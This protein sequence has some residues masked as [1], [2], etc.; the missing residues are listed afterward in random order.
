VA[1]LGLLHLVAPVIEG[2][3]TATAEVVA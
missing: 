2:H 3:A 1:F